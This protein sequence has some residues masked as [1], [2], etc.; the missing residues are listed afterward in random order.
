MGL[1][2]LNY[3]RHG[4]LSFSYQFS[5]LPLFPSVSSL[6]NFITFS[7]LTPLPS[8]SQ[9]LRSSLTNLTGTGT[10]LSWFVQLLK[11]P[12]TQLSLKQADKHIKHTACQILLHSRQVAALNDFPPLVF[13]RI[14]GLFGYLH[15]C[16]AWLNF[17]WSTETL[18]AIWQ[19]RKNCLNSSIDKIL[20][21]PINYFWQ[22]YF[23]F[24]EG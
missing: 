7:I 12:T 16:P 1:I 11:T 15:P 2:F 24:W 19:P 4:N 13:I 20:L 5:S 3:T 21:V 22:L 6:Q 9:G 23:W 10:D 17:N 14:V 8:N 18:Q